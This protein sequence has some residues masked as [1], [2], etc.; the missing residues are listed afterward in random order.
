MLFNGYLNSMKY[1]GLIDAPIYKERYVMNYDTQNQRSEKEPK[2]L[3]KKTPD[4]TTFM[5]IIV[6]IY[7]LLIIIKNHIM[8]KN[9]NFFI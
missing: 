9:G 7:Y 2:K 3:A 1:Q 6:L 4:H 5:T 8:T